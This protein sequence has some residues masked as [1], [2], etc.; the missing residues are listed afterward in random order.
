M[1]FK[2]VFRQKCHTPFNL[3]VQVPHFSSGFYIRHGQETFVSSKRSP[4]LYGS[5]GLLF[6]DAGGS[7][8]GIKRLGRKADDSPPSDTEIKSE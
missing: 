8:P 3:P 6:N 7:A 2:V 4:R 5:S 1:Q